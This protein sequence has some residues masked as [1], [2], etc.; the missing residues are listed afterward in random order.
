M[1]T[2]TLE[3]CEVGEFVTLWCIGTSRWDDDVVKI[4]SK[5]ILIELEHRS[6]A[7]SRFSSGARCKRN[8]F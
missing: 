5:G 4:K 3:D 1:K 2:L 8:S 7:I 6:G